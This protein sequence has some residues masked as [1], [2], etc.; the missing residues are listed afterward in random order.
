MAG[1]SGKGAFA[2]GGVPPGIPEIPPAVMPLVP[3]QPDRPDVRSDPG[4]LPPGLPSATI[5]VERRMAVSDRGKSAPRATHPWR[6]R[7]SGSGLETSSIGAA[8]IVSLAIAASVAGYAGGCSDD[9]GIEPF[10]SLQGVAVADLDGDGRN[11][12]AGGVSRISGPPPHPGHVRVWLQSAEPPGA[13]EAP[14]DHAVGPDPSR[15]VASDLDGDGLP[16]LVVASASSAAGG[17]PIDLLTVL[18]ADASRP[19]AFQP[20]RQIHLGA[21]ISHIAVGDADRDGRADVV[22]TTYGDGAGT[23]VLWGNPAGPGGLDPPSAID[24]SPAGALAIADIDADGWPDF[25]LDRGDTAW[26]ARHDP[27]ATRRFLPRIE[28]ASGRNLSCLTVAD[29]DL[30]GLPDLLLGSRETMDAGAPGELLTL[31]NDAAEPGRFLPGQRLAMAGHAFECIARDMDL[32]A[33]PDIVAAEPIYRSLDRDMIEV[34]LGDPAQPGA[35]RSPVQNVTRSTNAYSAACGDVDGDGWPDVVVPA[36]D[37]TVAIL[38]QD[39]ARPGTL[40][41]PRRPPDVAGAT[42]RRRP[43][44]GARARAGEPMPLAGE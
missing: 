37:G 25:V 24:A 34:F 19:G 15:V 2:A 7:R 26:V 4:P 35:F 38:I 41:A 23:A 17:P 16:D 29:L 39:P 31:R 28:L 27:S 44:P 3:L 6:S 40:L 43:R 13:F 20:G 14:V 10:D 8:G 42:Q 1:A 18:I 32:D 36:T 5:V 30:D 33:L 11:D 9:A 22:A 12:I 21:R